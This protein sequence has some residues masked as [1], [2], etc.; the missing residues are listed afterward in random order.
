MS[1]SPSSGNLVGNS[2]SVEW[3]QPVKHKYN[4]YQLEL[5]GALSVSW[6]YAF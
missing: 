5:D 6:G 3:L 1:V 4:G 2:F